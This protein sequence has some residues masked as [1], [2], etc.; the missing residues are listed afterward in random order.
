MIVNGIDLDGLAQDA[1]VLDFPDE[2]PGRTV[3][4]DADFLA[5]QCSAEKADGTDTK[6]W[7]D[8]K[9]N[10]LVAVHTLK[11]LAGATKVHLHLTSST[12]DKGDRFELAMLKEYQANRADKVKPRY[13]NVMREWLTAEFPATQHQ[14][15]EADDGMSSEQYAAIKK[16]SGHLSII[17]SKDK[18]LSMV[19]GL[20]LDW[21]TGAIEHSGSEFGKL[22]L[23]ERTTAGGNPVKKVK[24]IGQKFF[25]AQ[26]LMGDAADNISGL[27]LVTPTYLI[28]IGELPKAIL[29]MRAKLETSVNGLDLIKYE[30]KLSQV[31]P[32]KCG[33]IMALKLL[34]DVKTNRDAFMLVKELYSHGEYRNWRDNT[35]ITWQNAFV[36]EAQL[37]WMR[38]EK[39]DPMD[40]A[41]WWREITR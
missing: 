18:D 39:H 12:S 20:H 29:D 25:W 34:E 40:V 30:A 37:L 16:G 27:P 17:A 41:K 7:E 22:W 10:A 15:C 1:S 6:T 24:G 35:S 28:K 21:D 8:M 32:K 38:R 3:H 9:H 26:M 31:G 11:S 5:Y 14:K 4:I 23:H 36:S 19:P 2:V 13:L 33:Q